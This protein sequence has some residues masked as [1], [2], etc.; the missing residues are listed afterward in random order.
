MR[1]D[2]N[3]KVF[4]GKFDWYYLDKE[5]GYFPTDKAPKEAVEAM[6]R[7]NSYAFKNAKKKIQ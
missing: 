2:K 7:Y 4:A 6:K 3:F 1:I 5:N